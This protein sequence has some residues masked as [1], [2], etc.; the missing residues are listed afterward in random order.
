MKTGIGKFLLL[1]WIGFSPAVSG[2][3]EVGPAYLNRMNLDKQ[4]VGLDTGM[5]LSLS[6]STDRGDLEFQMLFSQDKLVSG[7]QM[8]DRNVLF[9]TNWGGGLADVKVDTRTEERYRLWDFGLRY[10]HQISDEFD[11]G[12][13]TVL[14]VLE[15]Q[16]ETTVAYPSS[17]FLVIVTPHYQNTTIKETYFL[18][19]IPL[20]ARLFMPLSRQKR[21]WGNVILA[22]EYLI[23]I[24]GN[25]GVT[26]QNAPIKNFGGARFM[27][28]F[29]VG[30]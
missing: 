18:P 20:G 21:V 24:G 15:K 2:A 7:N 22:G 5:G 12:I 9:L 13:G 23:P 19:G 14:N 26:I 16:T 27:C 17:P 8:M 10:W 11:V 1:L 6:N 25:S 4:A 29:K 3:W 28:S 30:F